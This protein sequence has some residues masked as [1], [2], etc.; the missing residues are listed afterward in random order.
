MLKH[1][2]KHGIINVVEDVQVLARIA[3]RVTKGVSWIT[4]YQKMAISFQESIDEG[5]L[6]RIFKASKHEAWLKV[7]KIADIVQ[8][9]RV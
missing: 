9:K 2:L 3:S 5:Q 7:V 6:W 8:N 1:L 4:L